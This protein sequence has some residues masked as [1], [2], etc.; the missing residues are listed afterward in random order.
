MELIEV[1]NDAHIAVAKSL[2]VRIASGGSP[3]TTAR[4]TSR[5]RKDGQ[6]RGQRSV[7]VSA[8]ESVS[9]TEGESSRVAASEAAGQTFVSG[10][11]PSPL[12]G[13]AD[14]NSFPDAL[15]RSGFG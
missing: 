6:L 15:L 9:A 11:V 4:D 5:S 2:L 3:A 13:Y 10:V 14:E 1:N 7:S 8:G 12:R